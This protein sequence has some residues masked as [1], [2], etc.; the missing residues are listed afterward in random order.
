MNLKTIC[1]ALSLAAAGLGHA[2]GI[3]DNPDW[4]E[5]EVPPPPSFDLTK[6]LTFEASPGS[7]LVYGVD[8]ATVS[9]SKSDSLVRYVIVATGPSGAKNILY[10]VLRCATGEAKTYARYIPEGRWQAV[11]NAEWRSVYGANPSQHALRFA[12]AG[13]CDSAAPVG[14]VKELVN[15]LKN[16]NAHSNAN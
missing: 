3:L 7:S 6:L 13:A 14:S 15:K 2:Q 10:E 12:K 8:P 1:L 9:I 11:K 5:S 4:K 16:Y